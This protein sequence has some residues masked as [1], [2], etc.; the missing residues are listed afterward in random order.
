MDGGKDEEVQLCPKKPSNS[1]PRLLLAGIG[2]GSLC[3]CP[4]RRGWE[5]WLGEGTPSQ[6]KEAPNNVL[7]RAC[8]NL[9]EFDI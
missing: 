4:G 6:H 3:R 9:E 7:L 8:T 2:L 1:K 5:V